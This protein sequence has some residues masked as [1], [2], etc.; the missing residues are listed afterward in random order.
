M[1]YQSAPGARDLLPLD[2]AQKNWIEDRLYQVFHQWGY[3]RI[4]TSTL[5]RLD[6]LMAGGAI[7]RSTVIQL[8]Q[9]QEELGLRPEVTA[10]IAR[11]AATRKYFNRVTNPK[12]FY[13]SANVF[14]R[15]PKGDYGQQ[16]EFYQAGVELLGAGGVAADAEILLLLADC[17]QA[18]EFSLDQW[19]WVIGE[20][21]L[22]QSLLSSFPAEYQKPIR[23]AISSLDY[24]A[25]QQLNLPEDLQQRAQLLFNLRG[26]P[27]QVFQK[28]TALDLTPEEQSKLENLKT[29]IDLLQESRPNQP[30]LPI[31]V[32]LSLI[33][34]FDYYSGIVFEVA[35]RQGTEVKILGQGG[36]YDQLVAVYHPQHE[37]LPGIGFCLNIEALQQVLQG[38]DRLPTE[39]PASDCL[40]VP[41]THR[42]LGAAFTYA[43]TLRSQ[44]PSIRVQVNLLEWETQEAV[45]NYAKERRIHQIA[46]IDAQGNPQIESIS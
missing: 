7:N 30:P 21:G 20:A 3:H 16:Q 39:I 34:T 19:V 44:T 38:G 31:I 2:V 29:L 33:R 23:E 24:I 18:L 11:T 37:S 35:S 9:G 28:L 5:E 14:V 27:S 4:I 6:T 43:E 36:R 12:R 25:L 40:V 22:T 46:W 32:D 41:L 17:L 1:V 15:S 8:Q 26:E 42:A 45:K 10:S 13:Y